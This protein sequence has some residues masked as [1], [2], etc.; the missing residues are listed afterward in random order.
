[1]PI[2]ITRTHDSLMRGT[3]S[4]FGYGWSLGN[5]VQLEI[6]NTQ[7]VTLTING[8][9][10]TFY[11]RGNPLPTT[12]YDTN[13]LLQSVTTHP[14]PST[15]Y[16][17]SYTYNMINPVTVSYPD[18]T[19]STGLKT[20]TTYPDNSTLTQI[21]DTYGKVVSGH[22]FRGCRDSVMFRPP[23]LFIVPTAAHTVAGQPGLLRPGL[24]CIVAS[25]RTGYTNR[26]NS[27]QRL[28]SSD[29]L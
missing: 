10:R 9:R 23:V 17:T 22:L 6:G 4:D 1:M 25:A 11:S 27:R 18:G 12:T 2:Q 19:T 16:T 5:K 3:S 13:G 24:S 26:P 21:S 20:T 8:Q 15:S 29:V 28:L 14:D 7:D